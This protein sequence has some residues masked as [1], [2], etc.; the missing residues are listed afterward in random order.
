MSSAFTE[1]I[2]EDVAL[3]WLEA[4]GWLVA[5]GPDVAPDMPAAERADY[6]EVGL[7]QRLRDALA[8][9]NPALPAEAL[10][11]AYRKLTRPEGAELIHRNRALPRL[12]V[13][14]CAVDYRSNDGLVAAPQ[15]KMATVQLA[16]RPEVGA[17]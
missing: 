14:G 7:V 1:S 5:N 4:I 10:E 15:A 13:D 9:L 2:V 16:N 6:G 12:P 17:P 3:A 11:D 8:R